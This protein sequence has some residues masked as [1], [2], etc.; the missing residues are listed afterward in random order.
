MVSVG[1][2]GGIQSFELHGLVTLRITDEKY[3]KIKVYLDNK[4]KRGIQLQVLFVLNLQIIIID[5]IT[6]LALN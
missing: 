6:Y 4:D 5:Q 3:A 2:D 1:K